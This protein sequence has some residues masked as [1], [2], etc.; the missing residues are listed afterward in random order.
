MAEKLRTIP[1]TLRVKNLVD[2]PIDGTLYH[3]ELKLVR[4]EQ[5]SVYKVKDVLKKRKCN[6][7]I[8]FRE[9]EGGTGSTYGS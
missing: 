6:E 3:Q 8:E 9:M 7:N 5:D 4:V 1:S 2:E